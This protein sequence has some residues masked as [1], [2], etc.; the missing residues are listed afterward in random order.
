MITGKMS[1]LPIAHAVIRPTK[2]IHVTIL[3]IGILSQFELQTDPSQECL[4]I[5]CDGTTDFNVFAAI[6]FR[7]MISLYNDCQQK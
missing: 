1:I 6:G 7:Q 5:M 3:V 2:T 4:N